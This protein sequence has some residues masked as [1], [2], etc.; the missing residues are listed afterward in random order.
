[1]RIVRSVEKS[2]RR[3]WVDISAAVCAIAISAASLFI[4][5]RQN[6]LMEKQ[7]SASTWP[8]LEFDSSN[9]DDQGGSEIDFEIRNAGV[10][11]AKIHSFRMTFDDKP[12]ANSRQILEKCCSDDQPLPHLN[13][14]TSGV[15]HS[16]L[17]PNEKIHFF[18]FKQTPEVATYWHRLDTQR[19][20]IHVN[21][22]YCSALD[23]CWILDSARQE[24]ERTKTCSVSAQEF[25]E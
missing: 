23:E 11:P 12:I 9:L 8:V 2:G 20:K 24:Q 18:R 10:G 17:A 16:V 1:M 6:A 3:S 13:F 7:L 25:T 22:C 5:I 14:I 4:A 15:N 21:A 19:W